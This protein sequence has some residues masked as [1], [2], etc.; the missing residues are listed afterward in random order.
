MAGLHRCRERSHKL[1][2]K[3]RGYS[4]RVNH[5]CRQFPVWGTIVDVDC[6]S[7]SVGGA[8]LDRAMETVIEFCEDVDRDFS[9][10][11]DGSWVTRLRQGKVVIGDCPDDVRAVW[12]LCLRAKDLSDG[13]FDPWAEG[14]LCD[15]MATAVMVGGQ[16]SVNWFGQ[17]E[18]QGYQ[19]FAMNRHEQSAWEI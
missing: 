5:L 1:V 4:E 9:T 10:Y 6:F 11:K 14:W 19:V 13:A 17:P 15:A 8:Q 3:A 12:D 18:L 7:Q 2:C 16:D